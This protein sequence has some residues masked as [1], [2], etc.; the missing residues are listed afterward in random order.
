[1]N[2][3]VVQNMYAWTNG[4]TKLRNVVTTLRLFLNGEGQC[5]KEKDSGMFYMVLKEINT[6]KKLN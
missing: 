3:K 1:M 2:I 6:T 5:F 4:C